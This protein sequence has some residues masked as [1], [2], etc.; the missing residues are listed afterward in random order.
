MNLKL[1]AGH[2]W[3]DMLQ[4][5]EVWFNARKGRATASQFKKIL[6]GT[7]KLST[8]ADAYARK[9]ARETVMADP[10]EFAGN[11]FTDWGNEHEPEARETYIRE[12]GAAVVEVGFVTSKAMP[13][14]GCSPDGL[15]LG[16]NGQP[17][18]G[19]EIK[20]PAI[21]TL[22]EWMMAGEL[23]AD[24]L[25]QVHGSMIVT[26]LRRW[27]FVGYHPGAPLF[28]QSAEWNAYTDKMAA[29]VEE[30][31]IRYATIRP[32]V[33]GL[34]GVGQVAETLEVEALI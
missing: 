4:G 15:I 21:D 13:C 33:L 34:L 31:V 7:G 18:S 29:A 24:H 9:L 28:L 23:P 22:V 10:Q 20:C 12:T 26:G 6:T 5:S 2:V 32:A 17:I 25:A 27:E 14:V 19:L 1:P 16:P 11:K 30:F 8:Q 3:P